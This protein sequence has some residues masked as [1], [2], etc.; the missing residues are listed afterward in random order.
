MTYSSLRRLASSCGSL[1]KSLESG[2]GTFPSEI[3]QIYASH[4][5]WKHIEL[6]ELHYAE[7]S[8]IL[9]NIFKH[10]YISKHNIKRTRY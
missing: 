10:K 2:K 1:P 3:G 5:F 9:I 6:S 7:I 8:W 4:K